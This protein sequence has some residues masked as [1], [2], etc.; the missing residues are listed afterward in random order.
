MLCPA[1]KQ[2]A[3]PFPQ[4]HWLKSRQTLQN[5]Q[6]FCTEPPPSGW[7]RFRF[8]ARTLLYPATHL[9]RDPALRPRNPPAAG[10][11]HS[12]RYWPPWNKSNSKTHLVWPGVQDCR[13]WAR[14][15]MFR[16][17]LRISRHITTPLGN[18]AL[19]TFRI[20]HF[21]VDIVGPIQHQTVPDTAL[22]Q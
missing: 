19:P 21:H 3:R 2:S 20:Q 11:Q 14:A 17:R 22:R 8:P 9:Q 12:P 7:R 15:C 18:F 4:R 1:W 13:T 10:V 16:Q 6:P 5:S